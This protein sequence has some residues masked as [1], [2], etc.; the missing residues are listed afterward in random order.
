MPTDLV[1]ARKNS[2][3]LTELRARLI[4]LE[5]IEAQRRNSTTV[6]VLATAHHHSA[7]IDTPPNGLHARQ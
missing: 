6:G 5:L 2:D 7:R 1:P 3:R 4:A